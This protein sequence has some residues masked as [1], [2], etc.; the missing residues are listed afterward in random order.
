MGAPRQGGGHIQLP[1]VL[2]EPASHTATSHRHLRLPGHHQRRNE[3]PVSRAAAHGA[4]GRVGRDGR[5]LRAEGTKGAAGSHAHCANCSVAAPAATTP[6]AAAA[7]CFQLP[8]SSPIPTTDLQC[9]LSSAS[10]TALHKHLEVVLQRQVGGARVEQ[11]QQGGSTHVSL[12]QIEQQHGGS[13]H[14]SQP[15]GPL[16]SRLACEGEQLPGVTA[17][18]LDLQQQRRCVLQAAGGRPEGGYLAACL[19]VKGAPLAVLCRLHRWNSCAAVQL[20]ST[21]MQLRA[22]S[23]SM[24]AKIAGH[25]TSRP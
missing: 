7:A 8:L 24:A 17:R 6:A 23:S 21:C 4:H 1:P 20:G 15:S 10:S 12:P 14:I 5:L 19:A 11:I 18:E 9:Q 22:A 25:G 3:G 16:K 2:P 13:T